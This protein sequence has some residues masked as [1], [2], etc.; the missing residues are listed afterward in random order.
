MH[1]LCM[2]F[3]FPLPLLG[4][5]VLLRAPLRGEK[6]GIRWAWHW[7]Q[8]H[9]A[10]IQPPASTGL[11]ALPCSLPGSGIVLASQP[12]L[13][14]S[15]LVCHPEPCPLAFPPLTPRRPAG[16]QRWGLGARAGRE[17]QLLATCSSEVESKG[18]HSG[19]FRKFAAEVTLPVS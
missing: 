11:P 15:L 6:V 5:Q 12:H 18:A 17:G 9:S 16:G 10:R 1:A 3:L 4:R 8:G 7:A 14:T 2:P 13:L 19:I